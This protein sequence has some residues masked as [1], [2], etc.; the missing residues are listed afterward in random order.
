MTQDNRV[1]EID[2][3]PGLLVK[4]QS[5]RRR[6]TSLAES[7]GAWLLVLFSS[8]A[9]I[10]WVAIVFT[11]S[12]ARFVVF[13]PRAKTGF[14]VLVALLALFAAL[15]LFLFPAQHVRHRMSWLALGFFILGVGGLIFGYIAPLLNG[16]ENFNAALYETLTIRTLAFLSF[17]IGLATVHPPRVPARMFLLA[18]PLVGLVGALLELEAQRLPALS[19]L[20]SVE[21]VAETSR[22]TMP[23][24]T[25]WHWGL[26]LLPLSIALVAVYGAARHAAV[27]A[28]G[29]W[30]IV[31]MVLLAGSQL[32][33]MFWPG[34]Y[35]PILTTSSL[36]RAGFTI[37]VAVG[38][39]LALVRI[40]AERE[41][42]LATE[43][44]YAARLL[45]LGRL[46]ANFASMVAHELGNPLTAIDRSA[47]LMA[48]D[49][50]TPLQEKAR[51]TIVAE[52]RLMTALLAD[53]R[54]AASAERE[55]FA[56]R[57]IPVSLDLL[58][59]DAAAYAQA[60]PGD[61]SVVLVEAPPVRVLADPERIAQVLRNLLSNAAKFSPAG[62]PIELRSTIDGKRVLVEV[63]DRGVGVHPDDVS[64]IF[65]K[66][67]RGRDQGGAPVPGVGL[68]LY[69]SRQLVRAHGSDLTFCSRP[70]GG[71]VFG[72][73][74][75]LA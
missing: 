71:A 8:A 35:S 39:V 14:E 57:P 46:R 61:H 44:A 11:I 4:R 10:A 60:L 54:G 25:A 34:A 29:P 47:D 43:R 74:L 23:G 59:A 16:E 31:A 36:L 55:D 17:A 67:G 75:E 69:V 72:F 42:T 13:A 51:D 15:I 65:E 28:F 7:R 63:T 52:T 49:P 21:S 45:D 20:T 56:I 12:S 38:V 58:M 40:S 68:G 73:E 3:P 6:W 66:L 9:V 64:R 70:G 5:I 33:S 24:L 53:A 27:E 18:V 32:H 19:H 62:A 48:I 50:L 1:G 41:E 30:L 22:T 2:R 37:I 26:S